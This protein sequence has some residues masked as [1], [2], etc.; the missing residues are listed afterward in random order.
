MQKLFSNKIEEDSWETT[1]KERSAHKESI[2]ASG[3]RDKNAESHIA[4][5]SKKSYLW[6]ASMERTVCWTL[7]PHK[8]LKSL[9]EEPCA[10]LNLFLK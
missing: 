6:V 3:Q 10:W 9:S 5:D 2:E 1:E 7:V 8:R 4:I